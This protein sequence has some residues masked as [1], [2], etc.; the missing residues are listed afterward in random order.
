MTAVVG[1]AAFAVCWL[2]L[3]G[4]ALVVHRSTRRALGVLD[5]R[6][7]AALLLALAL[8][9]LFVSLLVAVL[10]FAPAVGGLIVDEHCHPA[11]GCAAHVPVVH[12]DALYTV[13]LAVVAATAVLALLW[14]VARRLRSSL[15]VAS[16]LRSLAEPDERQRFETIESREQFAYCVGLLRP[17]IVVSRGL[18]ER[19]PA[20]QL[21]V[22]LRHEQ[23]HVV[24]R[25][26]LRLWL[27]GVAL[28]PMPR[29]AKR[30]LLAD[31]ALAGEQVCDRAAV[32]V[33]G[34]G[35]VID[36]LR[37]LASA[38]LPN[39]RRLRATFGGSATLASRIAALR[40][41]PSRRLPAYGAHVI[42]VVA[43]AACAVVAT[44]LVHHGTEWLLA[45]LS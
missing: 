32:A 39:G 17:K 15:K 28:L 19:L 14:A 36:T 42:I 33:G 22:V 31:L 40:E 12:A 18:L 11:T 9:P 44:D 4:L 29:H 27:A 2:V 43:Y 25:D 10:S 26:N 41:N 30:P 38:T 3:G 37:A 34:R 1:L 20:A 23:A 7:R 35:L 5:P 24:R 13:A 8:L 21:D 16:S 6:P 45:A